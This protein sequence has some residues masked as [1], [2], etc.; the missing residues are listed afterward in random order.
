M[1]H[2][3]HVD[4]ILSDYRQLTIKIPQA[5]VSKE[6]REMIQAWHSQHFKEM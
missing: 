2:N 4:Q 6:V 1:E 3:A 5:K